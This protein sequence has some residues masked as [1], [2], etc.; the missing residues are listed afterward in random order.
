MSAAI[1]AYCLMR[2]DNCGGAG[3]GCRALLHA[4]AGHAIH[5]LGRAPRRQCQPLAVAVQALPADA[6]VPLPVLVLAEGAAV[7][8]DVAA[9]A[10]LT[11]LTAAVPAALKGN[12]RRALKRVL[13]TEL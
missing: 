2:Y 12:R 7:A 6:V 11:G 4:G 9:A 13:Q 3:G 1:G 10:R 5:A 8:R